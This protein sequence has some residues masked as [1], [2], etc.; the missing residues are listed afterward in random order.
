MDELGYRP[1]AA[2]RT[3]R[4]RRSHSI[5]VLVSELH[6][7]F[8]SMILDGIDAV[9]MEHGYT[10]LI[11]RGQRQSQT[12]EDMLG[13]LLELQVDGIIAV[14]ERLER[15]VLTEASRATPLVTLTQTPRIPHVDTVV[16]DNREGARIAVQH[17]VGLGHSEIAM[18]A[19]AGEHA[20][21]E[22]IEGYR[23]AML[24]AGA[25]PRVIESALTEQGGYDATQ[26]L[27]SSSD[28]VT[29]IFAANDICAFGVIDAI[30]E[31]G[32]N[33]PDDISVIGYDNT[34]VSALRAV[35]LTT[36]DQFA[37]TIGTEAMRSLM[38]RIDHRGTPA[39]HITVPPRLVERATTGPPQRR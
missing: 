14:T 6:N 34:L 36:V 18:I 11:V 4:H 5:G 15:P 7:P 21:A 17:L 22:R 24:E 33:I 31:A 29:A 12:E 1:N 2:A 28:P 38:M 23:A 32:M 35:S 25:S 26:A 10:S 3:L 9:A 8:F 37:M 39:R 16:S 27:L 19:D 20:G 30:S 13:R